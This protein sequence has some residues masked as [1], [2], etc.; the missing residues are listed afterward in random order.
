MVQVEPSIRISGFVRPLRSGFGTVFSRKNQKK[1]FQ[2][3]Q[4]HKKNND[5][6]YNEKHQAQARV[7]GA[8]T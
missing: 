4:E 1:I 2:P 5:F 8:R 6:K 3:K 7:N